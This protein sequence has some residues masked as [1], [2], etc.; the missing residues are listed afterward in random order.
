MCGYLWPHKNGQC[1]AKG[2]TTA[3][4]VSLIILLKFFF[5]AQQITGSKKGSKPLPSHNY[6]HESHVLHVVSS[7]PSQK[8]DSSSDE[9]LYTLSSTA[10]TISSRVNVKIND[11]TVSI[12]INT[13]ASTDIKDERAFDEINHMNNLDLQPTT[14]CTFGY[15]ANS[16]L[17]V[18]GDNLLLAL[19]LILN[20]LSL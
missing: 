5:K 6:K 20:Q 7:E 11:I 13:G 12:I 1:P 18:Q 9:Y 2:Q 4:V 3:N 10:Y 16:Q 15:G 14:K 19:K 8:N 17:T